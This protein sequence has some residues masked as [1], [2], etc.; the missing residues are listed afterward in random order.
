MGDTCSVEW[1]LLTGMDPED[2]RELLAA[3]HRR[4]FGRGE[5]VF[6]R[7]DPADTL[8]LVAKGRFAARIVTPLGETVLLSVMSPGDAFGE[9]SL[10]EE[11]ARRSATIGALESGETRVLRK[12]DFDSLCRR[13]PEVQQL[14]LRALAQRVR[15][16]SELLVE[17]LWVPAELRVL[18]RVTELV[19]AY[20]SDADATTIPLT[21]EELAGLAGTSRATV[22]RVLRE[23][24][25]R[26]EVEL[27][28]GRTVVIDRDR[29]ARSARL[30]PS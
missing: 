8:H 6:H 28:R 17:A 22:N 23:A 25:R 7:D 2:Q 13:R 14:L 24:G 10:L 5:V 1:E 26:G 11:G 19:S 4:V 9:L 29:L 12:A 15:R 21:Q 20:G 3:T 18:R 30:R 27:R 16:L